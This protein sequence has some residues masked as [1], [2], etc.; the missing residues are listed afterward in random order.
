MKVVWDVDNTLRDLTGYLNKEYGFPIDPPTWDYI[1]NGKD[2]YSILLEDPEIFAKAPKTKYVE[3]ILDS[4]SE[5]ECW[6]VQE[7][8][9]R[10]YTDLWLEEHINIPYKVRYFDHFVDKYKA[11]QKIDGVIVDDYPKYESYEKVIIPH[12]EYNNLCGL[13]RYKNIAQLKYYI[14]AIK[15]DKLKKI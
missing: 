2:V 7:K 12:Y 10:K 14:W 15:N 5:I 13:R 4:F 8:P 11:L 9:W 1:H 3:T 6:T